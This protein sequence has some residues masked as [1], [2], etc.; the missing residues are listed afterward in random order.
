MP[1][2][3]E[4]RQAQDESGGKKP[5]V[6]PR[7][8]D[9]EQ[10]EDDG[11]FAEKDR[12]PGQWRGFDLLPAVCT[13]L[14]L[15]YHTDEED[16]AEREDQAWWRPASSDSRSRSRISSARSSAGSPLRFLIRAVSSM[17]GAKS[18]PPAASHPALL[19]RVLSHSL[20][21]LRRKTFSMSRMDWLETDELEEDRFQVLRSTRDRRLSF[22]Q[23]RQ[24]SLECH[25]AAID[26]AKMSDRL[27]DLAQQVAR[28]QDRASPA[29]GSACATTC[30]PR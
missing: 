2:P 16:G 14:D 25:A 20:R 27:L 3:E 26:D 30:E 1:A 21:T 17:S 4:R 23:L 5:D 28:Y 8:H 9:Q 18:P 10:G 24:R 22:R 11:D 19:R 29:P 6:E 15:R 7:E 12:P 13:N